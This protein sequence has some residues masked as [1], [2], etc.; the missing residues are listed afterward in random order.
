MFDVI[1]PTFNR[2][3]TLPRAINSVLNQTFSDFN[4]FIIDDGSTDSTSRVLDD[5]LNHPKVKILKQKNSGVSSARNLGIN[6]S[7]SP[8]IA[9]I[10]SD[11]EWLPEKLKIQSEQIKSHPSLKFFHSEEI[12]VRNEKR[13]NPKVQFSKSPEKLFERSLEHCLISPSTSV[14][15]R[16][17]LERVGLFDEDLKICEDYDLW[18]RIMLTEELGFYPKPLIT[19]YG[20]HSDQLSLQDPIMDYWRVKS[21]LKIQQFPDLTADVRE[22]IDETLKIKTRPLLRGLEK[23]SLKKRL[24]EM[25]KLLNPYLSDSQSSP[26]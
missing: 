7:Q 9:L 15:N 14:I 6:S 22:L 2:A 13:V 24:D 12:W 4:L 19:K 1:L 20:G 25:T 18:I 26:M 23:L 17:L 5:Y 11:D 16:A 3:D 8:W 10:D 21:L